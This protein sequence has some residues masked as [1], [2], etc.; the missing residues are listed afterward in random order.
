MITFDKSLILYPL[1]VQCFCI[2]FLTIGTI[3]VSY[4]FLK[5][6]ERLHLASVFICLLALIF[7]LSEAIILYSGW[8]EDA[9]LGMRF[10]RLEQLSLVWYAFAIPFFMIYMLDN[11]RSQVRTNAV[12]TGLGLIFSLVVTITAF[13]DPD[14]FVSQTLHR[15]TWLT[16]HGHYGRGEMGP[17]S[18]I[19]DYILMA[20]MLYLIVSFSIYL[21]LHRD[22]TYLVY[23]LGGSML[24]LVGAI[25]DLYYIYYRTHIILSDMFFSRFSL[26]L[27]LFVMFSIIGFMRKYMDQTRALEKVAQIQSLGILAGGIAHDFNNLLTAV[28]G[29]LSLARLK[30]E[31]GDVK[32]TGL[33]IQEA[34]GAS[35]RARD[36]TRQLLA[37]SKGGSPLKEVTSIRDIVRDTALFVASGSGVSCDFSFSENLMNVSIDINQISQVVQN[38]V[39]NAIQAM[40]KGGRI[41][42]SAENIN[43]FTRD[44]KSGRRGKFV[45]LSIRDTG[46]G[47]PKKI[48]HRIFDPYFTTRESGSGL[49]LTVSHSIIQNHGGFINVSSREGSGTLFEIFLP[50]TGDTAAGETSGAAPPADLSGSLL[51]MDDDASVLSVATKM[52]EHMG[53]TVTQALNGQQAVELYTNA[54]GVGRPYDCVILDL[55]IKGGTGGRETITALKAV[56]PDIKAIVSSGYSNDPVLSNYREY[57][58]AGVIVKPYRFDEL[59]KVLSSI[60]VQSLRRGTQ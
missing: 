24:C 3:I 40:P 5:S 8:I 51:V 36:L 18:F 38:M 52:L 37:F 60:M 46:P 27:T 53:F 15:A 34:E 1:I 28:I 42:L 55:T 56:N 35:L 7:V 23:V 19:K 39:L 4:T 17:L 29:N 20:M 21:S 47:I 25:D 54:L 2:G 50:A 48:I 10:H 13:T 6:R 12:L 14:F 30:S 11:N 57:G 44:P 22:L 9:R 49:G 59:R 41:S 31:E 58:F 16:H 45:K 26:G 43:L 32:Q 33:L